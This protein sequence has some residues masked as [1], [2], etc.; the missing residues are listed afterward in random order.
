M[1]LEM[2]PN[3]RKVDETVDPAQHVIVRD[4][5]LEAEAIETAPL[6]SPAVRP[7]ST[8]SPVATTRESAPNST[9]KRSFSTQFVD[10][11]R[12]LCAKSGHSSTQAAVR[13]PWP[14]GP[15]LADLRWAA[16]VQEGC[17]QDILNC[18]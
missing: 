4:V 1:G 2:R 14:N 3:V 18:R 17:R 13:H 5:P 6:A 16:F 7:S 11:S 8:K 15:T 10:S 12:L 9:I